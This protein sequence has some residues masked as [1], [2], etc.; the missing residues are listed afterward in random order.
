MYIV[1]ALP[2]IP[3]EIQ[4]VFFAYNLFLFSLHVHTAGSSVNSVLLDEFRKF[5]LGFTMVVYEEI[6]L[7]T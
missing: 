2:F 7:E 6:Y 3:Q 4:M 5:R 1:K